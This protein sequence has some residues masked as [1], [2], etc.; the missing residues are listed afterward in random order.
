MQ[1]VFFVLMRSRKKT[2]LWVLQVW[3]KVELNIFY[4]VFHNVQ[5]GSCVK[6]SPWLQQ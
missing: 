4:N 3:S 6:T 1:G 5:S 2:A